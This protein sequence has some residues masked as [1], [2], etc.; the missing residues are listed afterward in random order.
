MFT[1]KSTGVN[2]FLLSP[3]HP[4]LPLGLV[5]A[6]IRLPFL[7]VLSALLFPL[8]YV[9]CVLEALIPLVGF[10]FR[11]YIVSYI[12]RALLFSLGFHV[13]GVAMVHLRKEAVALR[14]PVRP[15]PPPV[16][17]KVYIVNQ[18]SWLDSL[19]VLSSLGCAWGA[20]S[21]AGELGRVSHFGA[22]LRYLSGPTPS[23]HT[24]RSSGSFFSTGESRSIACQPEGAPTNGK[25]LLTFTRGLGLLGERL[26][27]LPPNSPRPLVHTLGIHYANGA[28]NFSPC[29]LAAGSP[30]YHIFC[31]LTQPFSSVTLYALP[32]SFDPQPSDSL[33]TFSSPGVNPAVETAWPASIGAALEQ[34]LR[35]HGVKMVRLSSADH[36]R[37]VGLATNHKK[38]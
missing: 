15:S 16:R 28:G 19:V 35:G 31:L 17:G 12:A 18:S 4:F 33:S 22:V 29:F 26:A 32:S 27:S 30:W 36:E 23:R 21:D 24:A 14:P 7:V 5:F 10:L 2:P 3:Y 38:E 1:E 11:R 13:G 25:A 37:F 8:E 6:L 34:L 20:L 9:S